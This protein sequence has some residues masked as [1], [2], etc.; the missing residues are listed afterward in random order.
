M[1]RALRV[2]SVERGLDPRGFALVAFGGAG[3]LHA[4]ALARELGIRT[5][6]VPEAAGVLS[7]LGL[8]AADERR[9]E[10]RSR[11][12]P[13]AGAGELPAD[14]ELDLRY[15][16]QSHELAVPAAGDPAEA[17]HGLHEERYGFSDRGRPV[18]LV[19]VRRA[20][21]RPGPKVRLHG[22][23]RSVRGPAVVELPGAT[24]W[25]P[26]GWSGSTDAHGTLVLE[27]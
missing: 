5:V 8:V 6:L 24:C 18:E 15:A 4:C 12:E 16:G 17:F 11:V 9:D 3:P 10:A 7:A 27:R 21:T 22:A 25:V 23:A 1:L 13:L 2:V 20:E 14:A 26:D 19:A